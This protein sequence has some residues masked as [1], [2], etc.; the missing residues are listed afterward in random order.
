ME[1]GQIIT[2]TVNTII[3]TVLAHSSLPC[4]EHMHM[5]S[6]MHTHVRTQTHTETNTHTHTQ[7]HIYFLMF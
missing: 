3:R 2:V 1:T 6:H 7:W 5:H 4:L